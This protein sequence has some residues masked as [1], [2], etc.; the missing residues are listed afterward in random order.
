[1]NTVYRKTSVRFTVVLV[2]LLGLTGCGGAADEEPTAV[3]PVATETVLAEGETDCELTVLDETSDAVLERTE[4][5][6]GRVV[7]G[8]LIWADMDC[9]G[10]FGKA[11]V[12]AVQDFWD[13]DSYGDAAVWVAFNEIIPEEGGVWKGDCNNSEGVSRC[14]FDGGGIHEGQRLEVALTFAT[15]KQ[16]YRIVQVTEE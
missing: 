2:L 11:R 3:E 13:F 5:E 15:M 8:H 9:P 1:M 16:E 7:R 12:V 14:V 4:G 6:M 10:S